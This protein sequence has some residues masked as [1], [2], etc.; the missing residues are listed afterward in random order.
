MTAAPSELAA[1]QVLQEA[2]CCLFSWAGAKPQMPFP[3]PLPESV[4][5]AILRARDLLDSHA[6]GNPATADFEVLRLLFDRVALA[7][8]QQKTLATNYCQPVAIAD[9]EPPVPYPTQT[10]P[11][12]L[13]ALRS[14][15]QAIGTSLK[16]ED[17]NNIGLLEILLDK[18]GSC[19]SVCDRSKARTDDR[20]DV[21]LTDIARSTA[22]LAAAL[23]IDPKAENL[24]LVAGDLSGIQDFIYT[25]SSEGALKSLRARSF[26]LELVVEEVVQQLLAALQLPRTNVIYAGGGHL[27]ILAPDAKDVEEK[28]GSLR[29]RFNDWLRRRFQGKVFLA[30]GS[31]SFPVDRINNPEFG[32]TWTAVAAE[33]N[34]QKMQRFSDRID[35][36]LKPQEAHAACQ[37]CYRDDLEADKLGPLRKDD[38]DSARA[39][40]TCQEMFDLGGKLLKV[41]WI[42][43][44]RHNSYPGSIDR[45]RVYEDRQQADRTPRLVIRYF[46]LDEEVLPED[47]GPG[48]RLFPI[49]SWNVEDYRRGRASPLFLGNYAARS[50]VPEEPGVM[51]AREMS[52]KAEGV[53]RVGYLRMDVDRLGQIFAR[54]LGKHQNLPRV[55]GLSRLM[56][57]FFKV[58]L[59]QLARD[60][61]SN[62][63]GFQKLSEGDRRDLVFV[64]A[65][66]D[67]VFIGGAWNQTLE[68]AFDLY[69]S[70]RAYVGHNPALTFSAGIFLAGPKFPLYQAAKRAGD[71]EDA[72]KDNDRDSLTAFDCTFKWEEWLGDRALVGDRE[73]QAYLQPEKRPPLFGI[74]PMVDR[75]G[76]M[77]LSR[78]FAYN[79]LAVARLQ[80]QI[81]KEM[82]DRKLSK[83][84]CRDA[85]YFL[86]LPKV[87]YALARLPGETKRSQAFTEVRQSLK[88]PYNAPYFRAIAT[89]LDLL[90]R[91]R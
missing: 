91:N 87:A 76:K 79:L 77:Q 75:L 63:P 56:T 59:N 85:R 49:N 60:R 67:D 1:R 17:Y 41:R 48:D 54:G 57:Y 55:A 68:F 42:L 11:K 50:S 84:K 71:A 53:Q 30:L 33:L 12:D 21:A 61:A 83:E 18:F 37:V 27:Y 58:Y 86:H 4:G 19:L 26:Y 32:E 43:R 31:Q 66:G 73:V 45:L 9:D 25:I 16:A 35:E 81:V 29:S 13:K 7:A 82:K 47:M 8:G 20:A 14:Q 80:E 38:E 89:W 39:C 78:G 65:G 88:S 69:Q 23:A 36:V 44:S 5:K 40:P 2:V 24:R 72:A 64:Y 22:S 3:Q 6:I 34:Q 46:L 10:E 15:V 62:T 70:F 74:F 51:A 52:E 28:I 90:D